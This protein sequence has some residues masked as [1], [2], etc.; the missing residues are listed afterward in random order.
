MADPLGLPPNLPRRCNPYEAVQAVIA[1]A[2]QE[3]L[4]TKHLYQ[5]VDVSP[6]LIRKQMDTVPYQMLGSPGVLDQAVASLNQPWIARLFAGQDG[7]RLP[8]GTTIFDPPTVKTFC[9]RCEG[10]QPFNYEAPSVGGMPWFQVA[11]NEQIFALCYQCQGCKE[12][13]VSFMVTRVGLKL[14]LSGRS[15][16]ER[17]QVPT[18][19]PKG[20]ARYY[21]SAVI[22]YNWNEVLPALFMLRT[23]I[24]Q[25][26]RST[27]APAKYSDAPALCDAY[28]ATLDDAFK[29]HYPSLPDIYSRL[30]E[31]LHEAREDGELFVSQRTE[32]EKHLRAKKSWEEDHRTPG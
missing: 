15:I 16:I 29:G 27:L 7:S 2:F 18:F 4:N 17:V 25:H 12:F 8:H 30:S 23:L 20:V 28:N 21:S 6:K 24:E 13:R 19:I 10:V 22:A 31:A 1:F 5:H 32:I 14:T 9:E 11:G 3:L 26:M